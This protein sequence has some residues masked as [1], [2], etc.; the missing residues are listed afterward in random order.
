MAWSQL[1]ESTSHLWSA[2]IQSLLCIYVES[3]YGSG[4]K[5]QYRMQTFFVELAS[6]IIYSLFSRSSLLCVFYRIRMSTLYRD[7]GY[8]ARRELAVILNH[9]S[10][11][12]ADWK[13]LA[14]KMKF[15]YDTIVSLRGKGSPTQ[16]L[17]EKWEKT[18]G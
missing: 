7:L 5:D 15:S 14:D 2:N 12:G 9:E 6:Y 4:L 17:L 3:T 18:A 10:P 8:L 13:G 16:A 11:R 1:L